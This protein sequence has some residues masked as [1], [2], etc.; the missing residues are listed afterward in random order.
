MVN[1]QI[2]AGLSTAYTALRAANPDI[3]LLMPGLLDPTSGAQ[4]SRSAA[5]WRGNFNYTNAAV[6]VDLYTTEATEA[7]QWSQVQAWALNHTQALPIIVTELAPYV[8]ASLGVNMT[9]GV[10]NRT[11]AALANQGVPVGLWSG[12]YLCAPSM[13]ASAWLPGAL[14]P[15][16][17]WGRLAVSW[18][19]SYIG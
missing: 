18:I 16:N 9:E 8:D 11:F 19:R 12:E 5:G 7:G 15:L 17:Q 14:L 3:L 2:Q 4:Y 1:Q 10:F 13:L 6:A